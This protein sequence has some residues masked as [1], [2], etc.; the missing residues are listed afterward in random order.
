L[1]AQWLNIRALWLLLLLSIVWVLVWQA[2]AAAVFECGLHD[3]CMTLDAYLDCA[4]L[5]WCESLAQKMH[6]ALLLLCV[7][8][9]TRQTPCFDTVTYDKQ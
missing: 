8:S 5:Y 3:L 1:Y 7:A 2:N 9:T 6:A 4:W